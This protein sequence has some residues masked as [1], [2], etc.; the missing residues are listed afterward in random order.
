MA[1]AIAKCKLYLPAELVG[2][3]N[4]LFVAV[5]AGTGISQFSNIELLGFSDP[6]GQAVLAGDSVWFY[7]ETGHHRLSRQEHFATRRSWI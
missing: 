4:L 1:D 5:E 6:V 7:R 2:S 3:C